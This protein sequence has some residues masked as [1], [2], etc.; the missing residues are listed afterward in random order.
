MTNLEGLPSYFWLTSSRLKQPTRDD[1]PYTTEAL[2]QD[3]LRVQIAWDDCQASR[4]RDAIYGYLAA[5]QFGRLVGGG[6]TC[7]GTRTQRTAIASYQSIR[8]R[9]AVCCSHS[10]YR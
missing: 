2:K 9:G 6:K 8:K 1:V 10:L 4:A 7:S 5:L 3:L